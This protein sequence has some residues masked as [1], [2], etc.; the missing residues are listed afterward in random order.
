LS[1][2]T[3][4]QFVQRIPFCPARPQ[5]GQGFEVVQVVIGASARDAR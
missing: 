3:V 1:Q 5:A 2:P 4:L